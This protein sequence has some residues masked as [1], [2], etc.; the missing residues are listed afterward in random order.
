MPLT[1]CV[2]WK[3]TSWITR[4]STGCRFSIWDADEMQKTLFRELR[5]RDAREPRE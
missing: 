2:R 1:E 3:P 4:S 5:G